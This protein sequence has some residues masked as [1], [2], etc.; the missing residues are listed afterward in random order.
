MLG[1]QHVVYIHI[2]G[3]VA[4]GAVQRVAAHDLPLQGK[5]GGVGVKLQGDAGAHARLEAHEGSVGDFIIKRALHGGIA[6]G[7]EKIVLARGDVQA[8]METLAHQAFI[9]EL[10]LLFAKKRPKWAAYRETKGGT[11]LF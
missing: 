7:H 11:F 8:V 2:Q 3:A 4:V 6:A 10:Q 5:G 9:H 1:D